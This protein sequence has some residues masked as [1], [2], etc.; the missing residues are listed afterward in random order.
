MTRWLVLALLCAA[1]TFGP[2]WGA[3]GEEPPASAARRLSVP[4]N[5]FPDA[6]RAFERKDHVNAAGGFL[7]YLLTH[8]RDDERYEWAEFF[9]GICFKEMGFSHAA[10]DTLAGLVVQKPNSRIVSFS[11]E[12]LEQVSR[13]QPFDRERVLLDVLCEQEYGFVAPDLADFVHYNQGLYDWEHG[14]VEW[15]NDHFR[16]LQPDTYYYRKYRYQKALYLIYQDQL[17]AA[18]EVLEQ[19]ARDEHADPA[20]RDE[21]RITLARARYEQQQWQASELSY[22][23]LELPEQEQARY[24]LERAW[25]QKAQSPAHRSP[26]S[27]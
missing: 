25:A 2:A 17:G 21:V 9:L 4:E 1:P 6:Y 19:L 27:T 8:T 22:A 18:T 5:V 14:Y 26:S 10:V 23:K 15:G 11:L 20:L 16:S 7:D 24:L 3:V 13:T 12:L